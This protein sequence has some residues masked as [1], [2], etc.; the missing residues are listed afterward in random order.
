[1]HEEEEEED[2]EEGV[3]WNSS[4][5]KHRP[6][7]LRNERYRRFFRRPKTFSEVRAIR[8]RCVLTRVNSAKWHSQF[9]YPCS[10]TSVQCTSCCTFHDTRTSLVYTYVDTQRPL[11]PFVVFY[12][13]P[14]MW[15][16]MFTG[17]HVF[18]AA[19]VKREV[20]S[21]NKSACLL[22]IITIKAWGN[23]RGDVSPFNIRDPSNTVN[24]SLRTI[25]SEC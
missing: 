22:A 12:A 2:D 5:R 18:N 21:W 14:R 4:P 6:R 1:M 8:Q 11:P 10:N 16:P 15:G 24:F 23:A 3:G 19:Y 7:Y 17:A 13:H 9:Y 25:N 20:P